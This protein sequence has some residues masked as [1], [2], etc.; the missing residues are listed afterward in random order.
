MNII[1]GGEIVVI[2]ACDFGYVTQGLCISRQADGRKRVLISKGVNRHKYL[3]RLIVQCSSDMLVDHRDGN[4]LNNVRSNLRA[5]THPQNTFNRDSTAISGMK[6]VVKIGNGYRAEISH[7]GK[8][9]YLGFYVY[10]EQADQAY[11]DAADKLFGEYA[12]H[13]SRT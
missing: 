13:N 2:D 1:V 9:H 10:P 5:V 3:A 7:N 4:P 6:G 8:R 11:K 12:L